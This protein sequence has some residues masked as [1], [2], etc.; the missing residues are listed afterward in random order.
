[1]NEQIEELAR[2]ALENSLFEPIEP[3]LSVGEGETKVT[4]P[5]VFVE[6][7]AELMI[8]EC[9]ISCERNIFRNM[10]HKHNDAVRGAIGEICKSFDLDIEEVHKVIWSDDE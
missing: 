7:F 3:S 9:I 1:M 8:Y 10:D 4:I 6:K 5:L 2:R